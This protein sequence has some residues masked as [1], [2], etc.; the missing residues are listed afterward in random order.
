GN[1]CE[2]G[3]P[4]EPTGAADQKHRRPRPTRQRPQHG[5]LLLTQIELEQALDEA[6][7]AAWRRVA[8]AQRTVDE[9]EN[10]R[11]RGKLPSKQLFHRS[12]LAMQSAQWRLWIL[13]RHAARLVDQARR[14]C[15]RGRG[16]LAR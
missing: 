7:D 2:P 5:E 6:N 14:D 1:S 10:F 16:N 12:H 9:E 3:I 11:V 13:L 8:D 15:D 4:R